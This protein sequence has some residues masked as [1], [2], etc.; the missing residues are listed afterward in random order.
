M[1]AYFL[2]RRGLRTSVV[3]LA[4]SLA[5][6]LAPASAGRSAGLPKDERQSINLGVELERAR[7]W[8]DAIQH[9]EKAVK[10]WPE[11]KDLEYGLRRSK[12]HFAIE[13]RYTD[14]SFQRSMLA[15]SRSEASS[16]FDEI[17]S[18]IQAHYVEP[19][20]VTSFVAHGTESI[21][22]ALSDPRFL[23]AHVPVGM[24][25]N[26]E[27]LRSTLRR[28]SDYWNRPIHDRADAHRFIDHVCELAARDLGIKPVPVILE[29]VFGGCN[30]LDDYSSLLTPGRYTDLMSNIRGEFVGLGVEIKAE[31]G[32]GLLLVNVLPGS[33]A[34]EAGLLSGEH[35]VGIDGSDVRD[36][37]TD[38]AA[39]M[40]QGASGTRVAVEVRNP[41]SGASRRVALVRRPVTVKSIPVARIADVDHGIAYMQ[42]SC[43]QESTVQ[44]LDAALRDLRQQG[45]RALVLDVRGNPGGLLTAAVEVLDRFVDA[46][47][48]VETRG[49]THDQNLV[50]SAHRP[51]T[52]NLPLVLLIDSDSASASEIVAGAFKDSRRAMIVGRR[53]FGKWSVQSILPVRG[54][55]GLRLTTARFY[56]P[57]GH[58]L[59]KIGVRPDYEV[60]E[61]ERPRHHFRSPT[62][63][64]LESDG[65]LQKG[66]ELLRRQLA[67]R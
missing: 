66:L 25:P 47:V 64:N 49:R 61:P 36:M 4:L 27:A 19:V 10:F 45:M 59:S 5:V 65:D 46:G 51:G 29:Y 16:L 6:L 58:T 40:L 43:F 22:Q 38:E 1:P 34:A 17:L 20:S 57:H 60:A 32:Q 42:L 62:D 3:A 23:K 31:P 30:A 11:S 53:T 48:L 9:Y 15:M 50:Y 13:R 33:P 55:C 21:Y 41:L 7:K 54:Q 56:S 35:V 14:L 24:Q 8:V 67:L 52:W 37:T 12:I 63:L 26:A 2:L 18:R 39:S 28:Q 44:E